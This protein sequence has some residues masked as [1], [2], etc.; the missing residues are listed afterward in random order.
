MPSVARGTDSQWF[1]YIDLFLKLQRGSM[2]KQM[3]AAMV[4][5]LM[6]GTISTQAQTTTTAA[7]KSKGKAKSSKSKA[8]APAESAI[9][10]EIREMREKQ[11]S[12][13][14]QIDKLTDQLAAK[15]LELTTAT[16]TATAAQTAAQAATVETQSVS[17]SLQVN[18]DAVQA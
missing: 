18:T 17:T 16:A 10:R 2:T 9:L 6:V 1:L 12:Q 3:K 7:S 15:D 5:M 8:K 13:Q 11:A 14:A 4:A